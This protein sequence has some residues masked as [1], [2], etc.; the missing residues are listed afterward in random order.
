MTKEQEGITATLH[1]GE[2]IPFN[3]QLLT[4]GDLLVR[5]D[6]GK[7]TNIPRTLADIGQQFDQEGLT[8][9]QQLVDI[10]GLSDLNFIEFTHPDATPILFAGYVKSTTD[11]SQAVDH[12]LAVIVLSRSTDFGFSGSTQKWDH[13]LLPAAVLITGIEKQTHRLV[14]ATYQIEANSTHGRLDLDDMHF[15]SPLYEIRVMVS[16]QDFALPADIDQAK[17]SEV[18]NGVLT[19]A[20]IQKATENL[21]NQ[22]VTM[23]PINAVN[24]NPGFPLTGSRFIIAHYRRQLQDAAEQAG[25]YIKVVPNEV[26]ELGIADKWQITLPERLPENPKGVAFKP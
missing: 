24:A 20:M 3:R 5:A 21:P 6:R 12:A 14:A 2:R 15:R 23:L 1:S 18:I 8:F 4:L 16:D 9:A 25:V 26:V 19:N 11:T 17:P 13:H 10:F 22:R 7:T